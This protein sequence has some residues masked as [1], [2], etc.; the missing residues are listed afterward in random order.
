MS[1]V[2]GEPP[3]VHVARDDL[4]AKFWLDPL[5]LA[6]SAGFRPSDIRRIA[7]IIEDDQQRFLGAWDEFFS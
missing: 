3:N 1:F 4:E 5:R 7:S 6:Y 2:V